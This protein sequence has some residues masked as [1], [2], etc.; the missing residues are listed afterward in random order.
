MANSNFLKFLFETSQEETDAEAILEE[1][2]H[3][4]DLKVAAKPLVSALKELGITTDDIGLVYA[5][6]GVAV[7]ASTPDDYR[8][9]LEKLAGADA[10]NKLAEMGWVAAPSGEHGDSSLRVYFV[11]INKLT[12][13]AEEN[14]QK[15]PDLDDLI[16]KARE[17]GDEPT[18]EQA[19][20]RKKKEGSAKVES[21]EDMAKRML[22]WDSEGDTETVSCPIC[23]GSGV[24]LGSLGSV[25]HFR[26][27]QCGSDFE[28]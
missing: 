3:V 10:M 16:G 25:R 18:K 20:E 6:E 4:E 9:V 19:A 7:E 28:Q 14:S 11:Q 26:C 13:D 1:L 22:E 27:R 15:V 17:E 8:S 24:P 12:S 2:K 23:G 5:E 21:A